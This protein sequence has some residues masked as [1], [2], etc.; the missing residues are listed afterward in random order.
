MQVIVDERADEA[1]RAA[2]VSIFQGEHADEGATMLS[3]YRA[4]CTTVHEPLFAPIEIAVDVAGRT[5]SLRVSDLIETELEPLKNPVTGAAHR[6]RI[7]LPNGLEFRQAEVAS[8]RSKVSGTLAMEMS[9][10]HAHL[11]EGRLTSS[12]LQT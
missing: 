8:G 11:S 1:Q 10:S 4:M 12:G 9:D 5:A 7:E 3:I 6:A 2:L